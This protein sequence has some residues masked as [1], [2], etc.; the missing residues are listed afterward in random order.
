MTPEILVI[1]EKDRFS[2][3]LVEQGFSVI[4][5]PVVKTEPLEDLSQLERCLAE[6]EIFDGIFIT[7]SSAAEILLAKL[8]ESPRAFRGKFYVLG[9]RSDELL[10]KAGYETFFGAQAA[11]AAELL[12]L[13][14]ATEIEGKKFLF[15]S[16]DRS[17]R[18]IPET[19]KTV[20]EVQEVVVYKTVASADVENQSVEI[21]EKLRE[22]KIAAVCFFSPSGVEGFLEKFEGFRQRE[23]KVAAIGKTT[24]AAA[25]EKQLR[26]DFV[27]P[28]P[29]A[30]D[31]A[32]EF[33]EYLRKEL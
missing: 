4:N 12:K 16:G 28:K 27:S 17:L 3:I 7:S 20:A 30:D 8:D 29:A 15:P 23:T 1:R 33:S 6:S 9:K 19:L 25:L 24:A 26:V 10:K 5:F 32:L 2:S 11:T 18:V 14:P 31:F 22:A 13:I 21:K